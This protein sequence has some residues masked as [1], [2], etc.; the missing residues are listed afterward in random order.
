MSG[1][2]IGIVLIVVFAVIALVAAPTQN[3]S[4]SSPS[5]PELATAQ[6]ARAG[7]VIVRGKDSPEQL[8][9]NAWNGFHSYYCAY[10]LNSTGSDFYFVMYFVEGG[11][12]VAN[13]RDFVQLLETA[14]QTNHAI[15]VYV[16][17]S[18]GDFNAVVVYPWQ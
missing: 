14:C 8:T 15:G 9:V 5:R 12:L 6:S 13:N 18:S 17:D 11:N 10:Y 7:N 3:F 16:V 2:L 1:K 4:S